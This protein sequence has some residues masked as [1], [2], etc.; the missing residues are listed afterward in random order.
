MN[1]NYDNVFK[2]IIKNI[3]GTPRVLL[4][5]CC[6][7]CSSQVLTR[8]SDYFLVTVLYYNP[9]IEPFSEYEKSNKKGLSSHFLV[10]IKYLF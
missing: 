6:A 4:H 9:N 1:V 10:K 5:S 7:P 8:L 3:K 2:D